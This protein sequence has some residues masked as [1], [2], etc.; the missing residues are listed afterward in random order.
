MSCP[1]RD[2]G[3]WRITGRVAQCS[4]CHEL[5]RRMWFT[6]CTEHSAWLRVD[7]TARPKVRRQV[8]GWGISANFVSSVQYIFSAAELRQKNSVLEELEIKMFGQSTGWPG[9]FVLR[10]GA[11]NQLFLGVFLMFL[12]C[13][14]H[15]WWAQFHLGILGLVSIWDN[16]GIWPFFKIRFLSFFFIPV[17]QEYLNEIAPT[18]YGPNTLKT[19]RKPLRIADLQPPASGQDKPDTL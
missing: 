10:Q 15:K 6:V 9:W 19:S 17:V 14:D 4:C 2:L 11:V 13:L 18:I 16:P 3:W 1:A 7:I 5:S 8:A 12:A